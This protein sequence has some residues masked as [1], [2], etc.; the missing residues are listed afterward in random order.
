VT[1]LADRVAQLASTARHGADARESAGRLE[2][3]L[4]GALAEEGVFRMLVPAELGGGELP[5]GDVLDVLATLARADGS[6]GWCAMIG[7]TTGVLAGWLPRPGAEEVYGADPCVVTGGAYAPTG[8]ATDLGDGT[9][10]VTGRW[11]WGSGSE[12]CDWLLGGALVVDVDG[13]PLTGRAGLP[14]ARLCVARADEVEVLP[15]WDVLGMRATGSHDLAMDAVVVPASR[16]VSLLDDEP[17]AAGPLYRFPPFGLLALGIA[18]VSLGVG[19]AAMEATVD[20]LAGKRTM[21]IGRP[22]TARSTVR[23]ELSRC[24]AEL[25]AARALLAAEVG[26]A[27][28]AAVAG[29]TF[30]APERAALRLAATHAVSTV[31]DVTGRLHRLTGGTGVRH[32]AT[33]ERCFRDAHTA[34]AHVLVAERV[35]ESVGAVLVGDEPGVAEL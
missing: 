11:E 19:A 5:V 2:P 22:A 28:S 31:A 25:R 29:A 35:L 34:T 17:W 32:G 15:N 33:I 27:W 9:Y 1:A 4:A 8:R 18:S 26:D 21:G 20:L 10:R 23:A 30:G 16:T 24:E 12:H 6:V 7:A 13:A 14:V 3:D